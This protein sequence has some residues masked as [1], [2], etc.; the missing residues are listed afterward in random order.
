MGAEAGDDL[1]GQRIHAA[2]HQR[3]VGSHHG[4]VNGVLHSEGDDFVNFRSADGDA[5]GVLGNAA[6]A[7]EGEDFRDLGVLFQG[8]DDGVFPSAAAYNQ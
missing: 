2:Q 4:V 5:G 3:V 6:V 7:G 8:A 1:F